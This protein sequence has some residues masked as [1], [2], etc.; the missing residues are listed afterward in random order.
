MTG[1]AEKYIIEAVLFAS[2]EPLSAQQLQDYVPEGTSV[3]TLLQEL[4]QDYQQRGIRLQQYGDKWLFHT[5]DEAKSLL[6]PFKVEERKLS[7]A[8]T[9]TLTIIAYHGPVTR[10]EIEAIRGVQVSR[11]T[12]DILMEVDWI[13]PK[14]S[15]EGVARAWQWHVTDNFLSHFGLTSLEDLPGI[16]ELQ[17]AGFMPDMLRKFSD[18]DEYRDTETSDETASEDSDAEDIDELPSETA[19]NEALQH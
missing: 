19:S 15:H 4:Q 6:S 3:E 16:T 8:A 10:A 7:R 5:A 17:E 2:A 14:K 11:G 18:E 1:L 9:E 12:L 13:A